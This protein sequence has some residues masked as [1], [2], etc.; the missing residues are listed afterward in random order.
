[1]YVYIYAREGEY[2]VGFYR[3]NGSWYV[4]ND[5]RNTEHAA[6]RV[7]YLNGGKKSH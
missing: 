1:M 5:Y 4:E 6:A 3:P 7:S 2:E